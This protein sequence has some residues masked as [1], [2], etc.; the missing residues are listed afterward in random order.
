[1]IRA[2]ECRPAYAALTEPVCSFLCCET[3]DEWLAEALNHPEELLIDHANCE[4]KAAA[5]AMKLM[6]RYTNNAT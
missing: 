1:M 5:T 6:Y 2:T 3:P 4:K